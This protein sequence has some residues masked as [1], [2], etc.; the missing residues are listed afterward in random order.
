MTYGPVFTLN[1]EK[2]LKQGKNDVRELNFLRS[3]LFNQHHGKG[4]HVRT[5]LVNEIRYVSELYWL[6]RKVLHCA[7]RRAG[8]RLPEQLTCLPS[9]SYTDSD[10]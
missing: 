3:E 5:G 7:Y 2:N 10:T 4:L 9:T 1:I 8:Y 6:E